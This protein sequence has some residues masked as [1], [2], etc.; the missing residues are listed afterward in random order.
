MN[1][2]N[3]MRGSRAPDEIIGEHGMRRWWIL[4]RNRLFNVYLHQHR[5]DD[6]RLLHDHPAWN[7]SIRLAG[8]LVEYTPT[9]ASALGLAVNYLPDQL[10]F[11]CEH[12]DIEAVVPMGDSPY[13]QFV[14]FYRGEALVEPRLVGRLTFRPAWAAHRL[15][16]V[17]GRPAWTLWIRG[18]NRRAWGFYTPTGWIP[19]GQGRAYMAAED[20]RAR[21][22][23]ST[24]PT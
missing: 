17:E 11:E 10:R 6:A 12:P 7:V 21:A 8:Q 19:W 3:W 14:L 20:Q 22:A 18:P 23:C 24:R 13:R 2:P 16:L 9:P 5:G 4:P 1:W 15:E